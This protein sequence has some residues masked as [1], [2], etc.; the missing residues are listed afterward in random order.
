MSGPMSADERAPTTRDA[1]PNHEGPSRSSPY[2]VSRL[3]PPH[4]L[5]DVARQ[6]QEADA[7]LGAVAHARLSTIAEQMKRLKA[8]AER[9]LEETR[10]SLDLHRVRCSFAK[11]PGSVYHA[12]RRASGELW[13]SMI[14]PEEW[15]EPSS[16]RS[17][18][19][20]YRLEVD[21]SWTPLAGEH[22]GEPRGPSDV[23]APRELV[24]R[25]L[26]G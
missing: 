25:L 4:D 1:G 10:R 14:G 20:T 21:Q 26:S 12:Y 13:L 8:E 16:D 22:A 9:I 2:A 17:F 11:R 19:G 24:T 3:A 7:M 23:P 15:G 18:V 6:I 5:I